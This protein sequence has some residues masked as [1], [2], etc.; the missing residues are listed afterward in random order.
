M[1]RSR[2]E[3]VGKKKTTWAVA[4]VAEWLQQRGSVTIW[5]W[6]NSTVAL[7][8]EFT[9]VEVVGGASQPVIAQKCH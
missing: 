1:E 4:L 6:R 5:T 9:M 2:G 8:A 7:A 3:R